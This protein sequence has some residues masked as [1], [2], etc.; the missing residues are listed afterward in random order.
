M[1]RPP[2]PT[3]TAATRRAARN[4]DGV[5]LA[6]AGRCDS[7]EA[8][9]C[10]EAS[11]ADHRVIDCRCQSG[12]A[13]RDR[14]HGGVRQRR[15]SQR[16]RSAEQSGPG[17]DVPPRKRFA[18]SQSD[19][20]QPEPRESGGSRNHGAGAETVSQ[21][22]ER[23]RQQPHRH[24]SRQRHGGGARRRPACRRLSK[25]R[26]QV[27]ETDQSEIEHERL[28][29][30]GQPIARD[31]C[32]VR[33]TLKRP[34]CESRRCQRMATA[35]PVLRLTP[36]AAA[37]IA[38]YVRAVRA[39]PP[40]SARPPAARG[41]RLRAARKGLTTATTPPPPA[42]PAARRRLATTPRRSTL[43]LAVA[44]ARCRIRPIQP[45]AQIPRCATRSRGCRRVTERDGRRQYAGAAG[46][47]R[48]AGQHQPRHAARHRAQYRAG[49]DEAEAHAQRSTPAVA[50]PEHASRQQQAGQGE[51]AGVQQ[52]LL[53][54]PAD[55]KITHN[56]R[57]GDDGRRG[58]YGWDRGREQDRG[59]RLRH[60]GRR[61]CRRRLSSPFQFPPGPTAAAGNF[62]ST[63]RPQYQCH[64]RRQPAVLF[65]LFLKVGLATVLTATARAY[66]RPVRN[67]RSHSPS[68]ASAPRLVD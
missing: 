7:A 30:A 59:E 41:R 1:A 46:A 23:R 42:P 32:H 14:R 8:D 13:A 24:R 16:Q 19:P 12:P 54:Q 49:D 62:T 67:P 5:Q 53:C 40:A 60:S 9:D 66:T 36:S 22:S 58:I 48:G 44:P 51:G 38:A 10:G 56:R 45:D 2:T 3:T 52:P 35:T 37:S 29:V 21:R 26:Q 4:R 6:G 63:I 61:R 27:G 43:P 33:Q 47:Q 55:V 68:S 17:R 18:H 15:R 25:G 11:N 50:V 39:T 20:S 34:P 31:G 65:Q 57:D 64:Q 28:G